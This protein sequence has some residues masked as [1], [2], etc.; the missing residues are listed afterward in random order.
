MTLHVKPRGTWRRL[1][2][3][4][5]A[6]SLA[7]ALVAS[8]T[9]TPP[10]A[11]GGV[12]FE[13][14]DALQYR[15]G[16]TG[17]FRSI[18]VPGPDGEDWEIEFEVIDGLAIAEGD[19]ILGTVE[20]MEA[21]AGGGGVAALGN[22]VKVCPACPWPR[23][24]DAVVPYEFK[25]DWG[26]SA[27]GVDQNAM[28]RA[29]ILSAMQ[30]IEAVS[31]IRF[32]PH[33]GQPNR[34]IYH[35]SDGCS[36][37]IGM[38]PGGQYVNLSVDCGEG[39]VVHE[40]LHALGSWHEQQRQDRNGHVTILWD[41]IQPKMKY[42][43]ERKSY[44]VDIGAYDY[45]SI[46]HYHGGAFCKE[47]A[48]GAC[49]GPTIVTI[50]PGIPIGQ[51]GTLS[52]GDIAALNIM[53]PGLPP[54]VTITAPAQWS[55]CGR[56]TTSIYLVADVTDPEGLPVDVTWTSSVSG[57]LGTGNPL[58][59]FTGDMA[60][61]PHLVVAVAVDPQDNAGSD[62]VWVQITNDPPVVD[63]LAP[64]A[65][66][67]CVAEPVDFRA[68]VTDVN[69]PGATLPD[70]RVAWRVGS[71]PPF[72]T[73]KEATHSFS[74]VGSYRVFV[75]A[76]DEMEAFDEDHVDLTIAACTNLPPEVTITEPPG[77]VSY[78]LDGYD[79][80]LGLWYKDV[81][82]AGTAIDPEDGVLGGSAL[83]WTTNQTGVQDASLGTGESVTV[84]LYAESHTGVE[85]TITLT[86]TDKDGNARTAVV[87][88]FISTLG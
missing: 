65:G 66:S 45:D 9:E 35:T 38:R 18:V 2:A 50:P 26:V 67:Y 28:M 54:E 37:K 64:S 47:T 8:C 16:V 85:H 7:A 49:V 44:I 80:T 83:A 29:R 72:A 12:T 77:D 23:W 31:I 17:E 34:L 14:G 52:A 20:E 58:T 59:A 33:T 15:P 73:G 86:A 70:A 48:S 13:P 55:S 46:M 10:P 40:I 78:T 75:R 69:E 32:V 82:L 27:T 25:D 24:T 68:A 71:E 1:I 4:A 57:E 81:A 53:Y 6:A 36:S 39:T 56:R 43:F 3:V 88:I 60:Y 5:L 51:R 63:L 19:I 76:T 62:S 87:R 74:T 30:Q 61:G 21:L 41:N 84:R 11:G 22:A 42:N 79:D